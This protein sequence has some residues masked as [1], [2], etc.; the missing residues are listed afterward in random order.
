MNKNAVIKP[1]MITENGFGAFDE[2]TEDGKIHDEY[3]IN[4]LRNHIQA[5]S[6]AIE[7]GVE[8]WAYCPWLRLI[9]YL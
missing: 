8:M 5:I 1:L 4:Y 9:F 2:L 6:R 3:R 7:Y